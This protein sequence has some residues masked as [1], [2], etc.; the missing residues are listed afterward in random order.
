[1]QTELGYGQHNRVLLVA[2]RYLIGG[3]PSDILY[4]CAEQTSAITAPPSGL[5]APSSP[6]GAFSFCGSGK[7]LSNALSDQD[8]SS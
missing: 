4:L 2:K 3:T 6:C 8:R 5:K 7:F 1:M